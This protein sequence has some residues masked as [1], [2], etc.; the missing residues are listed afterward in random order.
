MARKKKIKSNKK[1]FNVI[2]KYLSEKD[3][4][5]QFSHIINYLKKKKLPHHKSLI[6]NILTSMLHKGLIVKE[7]RKYK[8][9]FAKNNI[10]KGEYSA[11]KGGYGFLIPE[12][13]SEDVFI[14]PSKTATA[15]NGDY[16][17]AVY[18]NRERGR[19]GEI[20]NILERKH[21][22]LIGYYMIEHNSKYIQPLD[23]CNDN[24]I[25]LKKTK[26]TKVAPGM[27]VEVEIEEKKGKLFAENIKK[28]FGFPEEKGVDTTA[29]MAKYGYDTNFPPVINKE[30][31]GISDDFSSEIKKRTDLRKQTIFTIDGKNAKDFDDAVSIRKKNNNYILGVHIADVSFYV[32]KDS[33]LDK[34]AYKR[35]NSVYFPD[36]VI[37]MLPHKLSSNICSLKEAEDRLAISVE[38]EIDTGGNIVNYNIFPSIISSSARLTYELVQKII[39]GKETSI[40]PKIKKSL[41]IMKALTKI[42]SQKRTSEGSLDFDLPDP[43]LV[44]KD[45]ELIGVS[46]YPRMFSHRMIE[47]FMLIAN[48]T[49]ADYLERNNLDLIYRIHEKPQISKLKE[50]KQTLSCLGFTLNLNKN[51]LAKQLQKITNVVKNKDEE[52]FIYILILK[53]LKLAKYSVKNKSHFGL[54]KEKYCHFTSPIR[55]YPDLII[56]RLVKQTI[57]SNYNGTYDTQSLEKISENCS[58]TERIAEEAEQELIEWRIIRFLKK[59]IGQEFYGRIMNFTKNGI[60]IELEDYFVLGSIPYHDLKD[61]F[62][63]PNKNRTKLTGTRTGKKSKIGERIKV[64][65]SSVDEFRKKLTFLPAYMSL[66][67]NKKC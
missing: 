41:E 25:D 12:N 11:A 58:K 4:G 17:E 10:I 8:T 19:E 46:S 67:K 43:L 51:N 53:S 20:I 27:L 30:L 61:D 14:P 47:E 9:M 63:L 29:I 2:L 15:L 55:R 39:D 66:K 35:G 54:Q 50:L 62:Y 49:I 31:K 42:L 52:S 5:A 23:P 32:K 44:Y 48:E 56:H 40:D 34:E 57:E 59:N 21:E 45:K 37:P 36:K 28:V 6:K 16:V 24:P 26:D 7:N 38:M 13:G 3:K 33:P 64:I 22:T 18:F 65:L 1:L 60:L